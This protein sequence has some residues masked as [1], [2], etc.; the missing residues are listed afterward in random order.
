VA[1]HEHNLLL[2]STPKSYAQLSA[3]SKAT[4]AAN[5]K[6]RLDVCHDMCGAVPFNCFVIE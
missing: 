4:D 5:N 2:F 1:S 6:E 3:D